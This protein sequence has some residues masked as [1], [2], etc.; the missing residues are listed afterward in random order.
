MLFHEVYGAY[1]STVSEILRYAVSGELTP[2][3]MKQICD[4]KAFSES[5]LK[6][7]PALTGGEW[8]LLNSDLST[9]L[10]SPPTTP[11][12]LLQKRWLK[13]ISLD[14]RMKLFGAEWGFLD[15]VQPLFRPEDIV[16]F[17]RYLDGDPFGDP[18]YISV[19]R[20]AL[21]GVRSGSA[22]EILYHSAKG[23]TRRL[24]CRLQGLEYSEKDDKFRLNVVGCRNVDMLRLAG[25]EEILLCPELYLR[26]VRQVPQKMLCMEAELTNWRNALER[27]MLH[28]A[29]FERETSHLGE[30]KYRLKVYYSENDETEM[31]IRVLSF[32]P[33]MRVYAPDSLV[34][35]IRRR[36]T[37]Q[38]KMGIR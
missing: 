17:D 3:L 25:I 24:K 22:A 6:I 10:K 16:Y 31:L 2:E 14:P 38:Y 35:E 4:E 27:A 18:H 19:F 11:L 36:L 29:H 15:G 13:A 9:P 12:T 21:E 33:M 7:I 23:N 5:F 32:G 1:F 26:P 8:Q 20:T 30:N 28:F 37:L 34:E